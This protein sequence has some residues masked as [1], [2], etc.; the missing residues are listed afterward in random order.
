M[1]EDKTEE[2]KPSILE[3]LSGRTKT[4]DEVDESKDEVKTMVD[5]PATTL[6]D[7]EPPAPEPP[8]AKIRVRQPTKPVTKT[9]A[10]PAP[11]TEN[12]SKVMVDP[13]V[14]PRT[15]TNRIASW[16]H[17]QLVMEKPQGARKYFRR[18]G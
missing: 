4:E 3:R 8:K 9:E 14:K 11:K 6:E 5:P 18:R 12:E 1:A 16:K 10:E 7:P 15:S 2:K 13:P 17:Q